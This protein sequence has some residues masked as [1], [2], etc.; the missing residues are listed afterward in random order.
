CAGRGMGWCLDERID[1][2][3]QRLSVSGKPD[4]RVQALERDTFLARKAEIGNQAFCATLMKTNREATPERFPEN[5]PILGDMVFWPKYGSHCQKIVAVNLMLAKYRWHGSNETVFRA[6][7][8]E[9]LIVDEWR[10]MQQVEGLRNGRSGRLRWMKLKG[11]MAV[12]SGIKA[13]RIRQLGNEAY[14]REI[15]KTA[16]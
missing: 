15:V 14:A 1:E 9:A 8:I 10:T 5:M 11:L 13:K 3:G 2:S 12:R 16:R 7:G 4:G 6:P